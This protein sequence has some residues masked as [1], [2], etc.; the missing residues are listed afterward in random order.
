MKKSVYKISKF[1]QRYYFLII[2]YIIYYIYLD[3]N[4]FAIDR[5]IF[6]TLMC[7]WK[8]SI[9]IFREKYAYFCCYFYN[10]NNFGINNIFY[11]LFL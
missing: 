5:M 11:K 9:R 7:V 4:I 2:Y 10:F 1:L 3:I 6:K 8:W